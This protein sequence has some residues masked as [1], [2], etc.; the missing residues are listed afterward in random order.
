[1]LTHVSI[2]AFLWFPIC[3]AFI[4]EDLRRLLK[5]VPMTPL[6]SSVSTSKR[7]SKYNR[8]TTRAQFRKVRPKET[9]VPPKPRK[10]RRPPEVVPCVLVDVVMTGTETTT[11]RVFVFDVVMTNAPIAGWIIT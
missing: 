2:I 11:G 8:R 9:P 7:M 1:M 3:T 5:T 4:P 6:L 10:E